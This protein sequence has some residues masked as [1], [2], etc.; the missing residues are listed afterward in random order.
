M[1]QDFFPATYSSILDRMDAVDPV[2]YARDRNYL[3]GPVTCLSP[4]FFFFLISA[5]QLLQSLLN[6]GYILK[7]SEKLIQELAWREYFQRVWQSLDDDIFQDI[8]NRYT[9][10]RHAAV[11][12]AVL[13]AATGIDV[14]DKGIQHLYTT[15]YMHN[16]LRMYTAS[17]TSVIAKAH[18]LNP[19]KWMYYHLLDGDLASNS[20]SWQWVAGSFSTRQYYC[21]QENINRFSHTSQKNTFLDRDYDQLPHMDIPDRLK[22]PGVFN[23]VTPLPAKQM[24]ALDHRLPLIIYNSYNLDP[25]WRKDEPAN[26]ILLLE[27]S[28]FKAYP[29]SEKVINFIISLAGNIEGIQVFAGE[30]A[31]LPGLQKF[32]A[33]YSKEHPAFPHYPGIRDERDWLFPEI[34]GF[35]PSFFKYWKKC[36]RSLF[37][38]T[39]NEAFVLP[40]GIKEQPAYL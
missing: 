16:H 12:K 8:R 20:C 38:T 18:W 11:P 15:G 10:I 31:G 13:D 25:L 3:D 5:R 7:Q 26:R 24:P 34:R 14:I 6:N 33:I 21:N 29:V 27:P 36:E 1:Q 32:P 28:H 17:I 22:E 23:P 39:E 9:G 2:A 30:L 40:A 4:Y 35:Y 19:S 37:G